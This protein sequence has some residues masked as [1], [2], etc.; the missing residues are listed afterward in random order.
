MD[1]IVTSK[2]QLKE[3][4]E[5]STK[6]AVILAFN[7]KEKKQSVNQNLT[8]EETAQLLRVS[9]Q[10]IRNYIAKGIIDAKKV[11]RRVLINKEHLLSKLDDV[12]SLKYKR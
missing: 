10:T 9:K 8:I 12:K 1:I 3:L 11:N 4:I 6:K 2:S 5:D 7:Q